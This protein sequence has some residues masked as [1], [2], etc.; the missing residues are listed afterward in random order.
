MLSKREDGTFMAGLFWVFLFPLF[1]GAKQIALTFDDSPMPDSGYFKSVDRSEELLRKLKELRVPRAMMFVNPCKGKEQNATFQQMKKYVDAGHLIGNHTCSHPRLDEVGYVEYTKD[2]SNA[3]HLLSS[4]FRGQ[5][6]FRFPFLNESHDIQLRDQV[7][8][9]LMKNQYRNGMVSVDNDDYIFSFKIN[10]AKNAGLQFDT[11]KVEKLFIE[12]VMGAVQFYDE[13][14]VKT[15]GYSPKH[16]LLLHE[17]DATVM[18][19]GPL[20]RELRHQGWEIIGV[21]QAF[22]DPVY[23][24]KPQNTYANNG[25]IAQISVEKTGKKIG[26]NHFETIKTKL[27]QILGL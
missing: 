13:L 20:V 14:A 19:L 2:I 21:D 8:D 4:L 17:M 16:V 1:A 24:E 23:L 5:K 11:K 9:W 3:D 18:F 10:Q 12:H 25:I 26:Y 7:R 15:L 6:F 22:R 27:N